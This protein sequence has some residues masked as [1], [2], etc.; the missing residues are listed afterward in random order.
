M[1]YILARTERKLE[2][3]C[4]IKDNDLSFWVGELLCWGAFELGSFCVVEL[5]SWRV[6]VLMSF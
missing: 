6:F 3:Y 2:R 4:K 5:L 1:A